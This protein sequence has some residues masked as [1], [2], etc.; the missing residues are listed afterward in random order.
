MEEAV[1]KITNF[2][3]IED[4]I[5][6]NSGTKNKGDVF[7]KSK[8]E[9]RIIFEQIQ[10]LDKQRIDINQAITNNI[11]AFSQILSSVNNDPSKAQFFKTIDNALNLY[12][13]LQNMLHQGS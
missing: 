8:G 1:Q 10:A 12:N 3:A 7:E 11:G 6:V 13:E 2:N 4:L 5:A 9:F